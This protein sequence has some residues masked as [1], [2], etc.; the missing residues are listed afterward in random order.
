MAPCFVPHCC[1]AD[2]T[3]FSHPINHSVVIFL[4]NE[5]RK[6]SSDLTTA[7]QLGARNEDSMKQEQKLTVSSMS[8]VVTSVMFYWWSH[9]AKSQDEM[10]DSGWGAGLFLKSP[11]CSTLRL[12][13]L[14]GLS[15]HS[16]GL[17]HEWSHYQ[18]ELPPKSFPA[19]VSI[20]GAYSS[21]IN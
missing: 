5:E 15:W 1:W 19:L 13:A 12:W 8:H 9:R 7:W 14:L 21:H 10:A 2:S 4:K 6:V 18:T 16:M 20:N 3:L 11:T 17:M